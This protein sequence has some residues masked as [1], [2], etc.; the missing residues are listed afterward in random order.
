MNFKQMHQ[1]LVGQI[2][3][4]L[5]N[6]LIILYFQFLNLLNPHFVSTDEVQ[7]I[8]LTVLNQNE[9]R[10]YNDLLDLATQTLNDLNCIKGLVPQSKFILFLH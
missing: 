10:S 3:K 5:P 6:S 2:L 1:L 7:L 8:L 9:I 4:E